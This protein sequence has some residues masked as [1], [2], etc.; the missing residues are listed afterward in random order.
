ME[1]NVRGRSST[2]LAFAR[3]ARTYW[4]S[5]YPRLHRELRHWRARAK[6]IPDQTLRAVAIEA[7]QTKIGNIEGA[8]AFATLVTPAHRMTTVRAVTAYQMAFDYLDSVSEMANPDPI[9]NGLQLNHALLVAVEPDA[10]HADYYAHTHASDNGYLHRLIDACRT[11]LRSLPS[12]PAV[13]EAARH[14]SARI[15]KYQGLNHGD[16]NGSHQKFDRWAQDEA[17]RLQA[18]HH[19]ETLRSWEVAAA[20]GSSLV[21]FALIAAAADSTTD[22]RDTTAIE[23]AYFPWLGAANSL[24]DSLIDQEEDGTLGQNRL[25]DYYASPA[26]AA[27]RLELILT[28]AIRQARK[29]ATDDGHTMIAA[30]MFNFYLSAPSA[31]LPEVRIMQ[32]HARKALG[33]LNTPTMLIMRARRAAARI[34]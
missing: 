22:G 5:V 29:L 10:E 16:L 9:A 33:D 23:H 31:C 1:T 26:E 34:R 4:L 28:E 30:A 3:A 20:A 8:A 12:F 6:A 17:A 15:V 24:L 32:E 21:I 14:A 25:L 13:K 19:G 2:M 18:H 7:Q 27:A 11:A